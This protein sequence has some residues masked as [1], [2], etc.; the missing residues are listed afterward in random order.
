M[1][2]VPQEG[3]T[4]QM[5]GSSLII[6]TETKDQVLDILNTDIYT[7]SGVWDV[8]NAQIWPFRSAVRTGL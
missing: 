3:K 1:S 5:I 6:V 7:R 8:E 2:D 4:P